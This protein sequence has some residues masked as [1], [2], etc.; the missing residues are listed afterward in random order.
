MQHARL[1]FP[2]EYCVRIAPFL[3][4]LAAFAA[5]EPVSA[6]TLDRVRETG[7]LTI[8]YRTDARPFSY[9]DESGTA[10]G[11]A[12]ALCKEIAEQIKS[13]KG[14]SMLSVEWV[15]VSVDDQFQAV[16]E[17]KVDLL[18]GAAETLTSR[19]DVDFSIPIFPGGIAALIRADA[20]VGLK[21]VLSGR[22]PSGPLWRGYPAQILRKQTFSVVAG[23]LGEKWLK[24]KLSEFQIDAEVAPVKNYEEGIRRVLDGSSDVFFA[25]RSILLD[26]AK[27][28]PSAGDLLVLER[29]FTY[30]PLALALERGDPDLR[31]V[32]DKIL[33]QFFGSE[34]FRDLYV[35]W[36]GEP[37]ENADTF[38]KWS[39]LPQ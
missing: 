32:V 29:Q 6:A 15:P 21:E 27:R 10:D 28:S 3:A 35:K 17:N 14:L 37:D 16:K 31:F 7:K 24:D 5:A 39:V 38:F 25:E 8:G 26:A 20:P 18:C 34:T 22:P 1:S 23:T 9:Q 2:N 33:S 36:F 30:A 12:V 11:Y 4:L 13:E 19:K